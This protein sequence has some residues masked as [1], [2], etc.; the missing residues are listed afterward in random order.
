MV[1]F[2]LRKDNTMKKATV[3]HNPTAG[4]EEHSKS[5]LISLLEKNDFECRYLSTKKKEWEKLEE[6]ADLIVV[7]GGDGTIRKT[8]KKLLE[9]K[10]LDKP[11]PIAVLPWGTANNIAKTL[12]IDDKGKNIISAWQHAPVKKFDVGKIYN[13]DDSDFFLESFGFGIFPYLMAKMQERKEG[14]EN[15]DESIKIALEVL[16]EIINSYEARHCKLTVDGTD[17]SGEFILAEV[18]NTQSIGP[19]LILSPLGDPGDGEFE[20][21]LVPE[22][23]KRKFAEYIF[24]KSRGIEETYQFHTLKGKEIAI[25]WEGTHVHADDKI[26]KLEKC[27]EVKVELKS[28]LLEFLVPGKLT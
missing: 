8:A 19:N 5:E 22:K 28:G 1:Q 27:K 6:E 3:I 11:F 13:V 17:H 14:I 16:Y 18:M 15:P 2:Y 4:D 9:K 12:G 24:N 7:A 25:S 21:I 20:V 26:I 10:L 23:H